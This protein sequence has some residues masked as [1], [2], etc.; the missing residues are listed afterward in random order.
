MSDYEQGFPGQ[1]Y[2]SIGYQPLIDPN[3]TGGFAAEYESIGYQPLID[4]DANG[5]AGQR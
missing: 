1:E 5:G 3:G 2:E 4:P